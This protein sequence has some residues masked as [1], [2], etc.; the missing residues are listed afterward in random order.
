MLAGRC[1]EL[2]VFYQRSATVSHGVKD[3]RGVTLLSALRA[4]MRTK[5][6]YITGGGDFTSCCTDVDARMHHALI[7]CQMLRCL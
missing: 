2:Q 4:S 7:G 1:A 6:P 3:L 5:R